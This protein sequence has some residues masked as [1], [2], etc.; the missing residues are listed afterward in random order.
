MIIGNLLE[1]IAALNAEQR[2]LLADKLN[3]ASI[4]DI[5]AG[6]DKRLADKMAAAAADPAMKPAIQF[7]IGGLR[8]PLPISANLIRL[9]QIQAGKVISAW[10]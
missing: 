3:E 10:P 1:A 5:K 8:T 6:A 9:Y 7:A 4:A 2:K